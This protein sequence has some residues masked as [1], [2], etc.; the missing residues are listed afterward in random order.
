MP[1]MPFIG[2]RISWLMLARNSLLARLASIALSRA[3]TRSV[4]VARSSAVRASTV[5]LELLLVLQQ[6][7]IAVL[8]LD[9]HVVEAVDQLA[10]LVVPGR[11]DAHVVA[12]LPRDRAGDVV[13][14]S[15]GSEIIR[16]SRGDSTNA[17]PKAHTSGRTRSRR[18]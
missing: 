1:M 3:V 13:S 2:V 8:D 17:R 9:E 18:Y 11:F 14:R 4:F 16:C 6:L 7:A 10:D 15:S 12:V 5:L